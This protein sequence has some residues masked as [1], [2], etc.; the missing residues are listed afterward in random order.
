MKALDLLNLLPEYQ[1]G[2][3]Q[4]IAHGRRAL[5]IDLASFAALRAE[6]TSLV[7]QEQA[8]RSFERSGYLM[9]HNAARRLRERYH[10]DNEREWLS[11]APIMLNW[12]G[13]ARAQLKQLDFDD[14]RGTFLAEVSWQDS[15]ESSQYLRH[16]HLSP[17]PVCWTLTGYLSGYF[18]LAFG[19]NLLCLESACC[20]SGATECLAVVKPIAAWSEAARKSADL[21]RFEEMRKRL[22][23]GQTQ[24]NPVEPQQQAAL[25]EALKEARFQV[26][27]NQVNPH[28]FF[29]TI[30]I[31]AKLAFLEGA[32]ET[33]AMAYALADLMRYSLRRFADTDGL[34]ALRDELE[35][36]RQYLLI[37]GTRF[38][39]R[40]TLNFEIDQAALDTRV[41]PL[42]LQ[43]LIEN[44][45]VHGLEPSER[46][47]QL[48]LSIQKAR[49]FI[50]VSV[51]DNGVGISREQ[52]HKLLN[53]ES[54]DL[55]MASGS[56]TTGLGLAHVRGRLRHYYGERCQLVVESEPG[57]GTT[58]RLLL[59]SDGS[60]LK[61]NAMDAEHL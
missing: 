33:E 39:D 44:A 60:A 11:A 30:N 51:Q 58:V 18:S 55:A 43:P 54:T 41:P 29:N 46:A 21:L 25:G 53:G 49:E 22:H 52:L 28:F 2:E 15:F 45:F 24:E 42:T 38:R 9:G 31:I 34:V 7:G 59:P 3:G 14:S 5:L 61:E 13:L 47:G 50:V 32:S 17:A 36:A 4:I 37:Q 23:P 27:Q 57:S 16:T 26:L 19:Q 48:L 20:G 10:W 40:L 6:L 1:S 35:H 8:R 12:S 56:H